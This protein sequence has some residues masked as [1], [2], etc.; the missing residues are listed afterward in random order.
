MTMLERNSDAIAH[1]LENCV[2]QNTLR[3]DFRR[4]T[5]RNCA[6]QFAMKDGIRLVRF[7]RK[8]RLVLIERGAAKS[9]LFGKGGCG[10]PQPTRVDA[11]RPQGPGRLLFVRR[12]ALILK[13]IQTYQERPDMR[14]ALT[15]DQFAMRSRVKT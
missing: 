5:N 4:Q 10:S 7:D 1:F 3:Y 15:Y 6:A 11:P 2:D 14:R 9:R 13:L 12:V 8:K